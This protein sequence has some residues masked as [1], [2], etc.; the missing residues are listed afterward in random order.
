[1]SLARQFL[2][3]SG[4][5]TKTTN[6]SSR[7]WKPPYCSLCWCSQSMRHQLSEQQR[8]RDSAD[9]MSPNL[10]STWLHVC[11][12]LYPRQHFPE[13]YPPHISR[14]DSTRPM[15][16]LPHAKN[17]KRGHCSLETL[18]KCV[19]RGSIPVDFRKPP[20]GWCWRTM[21]TPWGPQTVALFSQVCVKPGVL[22][23]QINHCYVLC[24][25]WCRSHWPS[26]LQSPVA[27]LT[28]H[29]TA[30]SFLDSTQWLPC[31]P[32]S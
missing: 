29:H 13:P 24:G 9:G 16:P 23:F 3:I 18:P 1:M 2:Y 25:L 19:C 10:L 7:I 11:V 15:A 12:L 32:D 26:L 28:V 6:L 22:P 20:L 14:L 8:N 31:F 4:A 17:G 30:F 5:A 21:G 27:V